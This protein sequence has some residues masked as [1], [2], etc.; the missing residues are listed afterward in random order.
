MHAAAVVTSHCILLLTAA[1]L[2]VSCSEH[3]MPALL[4]V[5]GHAA[6]KTSACRHFGFDQTATKALDAVLAFMPAA[7]NWAYNGAALGIGDFSNNARWTPYGGWE[8]PLQHY[9]AGALLWG[10]CA[11]LAARRPSIVAQVVI[12]LVCHILH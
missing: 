9:R 8:R 2:A 10:C 3:F 12:H 4:A 5:T 11:L 7:P 1:C 6:S